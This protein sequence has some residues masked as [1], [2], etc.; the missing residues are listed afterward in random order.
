MNIGLF[1]NKYIIASEITKQINQLKE[2][3]NNVEFTYI[4]KESDKNIN[5]DLIITIGGDGTLLNVIDLAV[6]TNIPVLGINA[7]RIGYLTEGN[8]KTIKKDLLKIINA[9]YYIEERFLL[10]LCIASDSYLALNDVCIMRNDFRIIDL[11]LYID[12]IF[13][14]KYRADGLIV[15]TPTG[16]TAYS[17]SAGGPVVEPNLETIIITPVCPHSLISRT[18]ILHPDRKVSIKC[19]KEVL[20]YVDGKFIDK[21]INEDGIFI[22]RSEKKLKLI[23]LKEVNF[24]KILREK[25]KE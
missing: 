12:N 13:A 8:L 19:T 18:L 17:L 24:Y 14:Q 21:R 1:I 23:R 9:N 4:N 11:D 5:F 16:S 22:K 2:Q 7:G 6:K 25:L 15:S 3:L 10:E 20:L